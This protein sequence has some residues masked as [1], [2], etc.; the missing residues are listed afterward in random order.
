[1][2]NNASFIILTFMLILDLSWHIV[3][4][5]TS[6]FQFHV[7]N[8]WANIV[9][10]VSLVPLGYKRG[11]WDLEFKEKYIN[12]FYIIFLIL[13]K[14]CHV[15]NDFIY[16]LWIQVT[17]F[18]QSHA[19][20]FYGCTESTFTHHCAYEIRRTTL[21]YSKYY[22]FI[23]RYYLSSKKPRTACYKRNMYKIILSMI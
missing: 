3:S 6:K 4:L 5:L 16:K 10:I 1:M 17:R 18:L 11:K 13:Q 12:V 14:L 20:E 22:P 2:I 9:Q 8:I 19:T 15:S 23:K 21:Y 7:T